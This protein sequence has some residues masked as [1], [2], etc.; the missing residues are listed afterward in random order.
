M[1]LALSMDA[2]LCLTKMSLIYERVEGRRIKL[3]QPTDIITLINSSLEAVNEEYKRYYDAFIRVLT[4]HEERELVLQGAA[5]YRGALIPEVP[6][7]RRPA[8]QPSGVIPMRTYRGVVVPESAPVHTEV[9]GTDAAPT[10]RPKKRRIYRGQ[11][12]E[13]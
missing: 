5:I 10:A 8:D 2:T 6:V 12:I 3:S 13:E 7:G 4:H 1:Q 11:V 9:N